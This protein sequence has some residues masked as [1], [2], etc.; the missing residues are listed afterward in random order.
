MFETSI[1]PADD[2]STAFVEKGDWTNFKWPGAE[3]LDI[4]AVLQ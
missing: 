4:T 1:H 3:S 2:A